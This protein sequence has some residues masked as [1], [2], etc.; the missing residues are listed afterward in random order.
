M[1]RTNVGLDIGSTAVR[2]AQVLEGDRPAVQRLGQVPLPLGAVEAGEVRRPDQVTE[3]IERLLAVSGIS[4]R[5]VWL[6]VE[7]ARMVVRQVD[8]PWLPEKELRDALAFQ[9]QDFIPMDAEDAVLDCILGEELSVDGQRMQ[10]VL[11]VAMHRSSVNAAIEATEDAGLMPVGVDASPF[12]A[13]RASA[14]GGPDEAR[15][16]VD[17]G[18]HITSVILHRGTKVRLVRILPIGGRNVTATIASN[19]GIEESAAELL[20]RGGQDPLASDGFDRTLSREA[21]ING[22]RPLVEDIAS[23]I[24]FSVRQEADFDVSRIVLTG[25]GSHLE[26]LTDLLDQR[27]HLPVERASIFGR[28][29]SLLA[30]E[31]GAMVEAGG[32]FSVAIGLALDQAPTEPK[33][34]SRRVRRGKV[35]R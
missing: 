5:E 7:S 15:A 8:L 25:G 1:A 9:A 33:G 17:I 12:A 11:L 28:V 13:V 4:Q 19:L 31:L 16:L 22:A 35:A 2:I 30:P 3:A 29:R 23:T 34:G 6:G 10:R 24:E 18:G 14:T 32:S 21:A 26:G 27:I 20:K